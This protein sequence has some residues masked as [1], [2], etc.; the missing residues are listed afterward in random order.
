[1]NI[2]CSSRVLGRL[3]P[4]AVLGLMLSACGGD[5][6][7]M[8]INAA[9]AP[10]EAQ[11]MAA[12][13]L[14]GPALWKLSDEDTTIYLFGT[15]HALKEDVKWFEGAVREAYEAADEVA[16]EA[17]DTQDAQRM[18][19]LVMKYAVD[20]QGRSLSSVIGEDNAQALREKLATLNISLQQIE[21]ME[22]WMAVMSVAQLQMQAAGFD[23]NYGVD[24]VLQNNAA[25]AG[26]VLTG[27][28]GAEAQL[29]MLDGFPEQQQI[30]WLELT[31]RDWDESGELLD[32][33]LSSWAS[34]NVADFAR[35]M[36][37]SMDEVPDLTQ[38]LLTDRNEG[39][40]DWNETR[41]AQPGT[42]FFAVGAGHLAGEDSVQDFLCERGLTAQRQ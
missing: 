7:P 1:M 27:I 39:F 21:P 31:L 13:S 36:I 18:A 41:M 23:A 17:T 2:R 19:Q 24:V 4:C 6:T 20:P 8:E 35:Q 22:P 25:D 3:T 11:V 33:L 38:A 30:E 42:V 10:C 14:D 12:S 15:F 26:K 16:L 32:D 29:A 37:D 5:D 28:E 40:A 34:G 9:D